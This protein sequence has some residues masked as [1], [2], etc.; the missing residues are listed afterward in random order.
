MSCGQW[1]GHVLCLK[2]QPEQCSDCVIVPVQRSKLL[3]TSLLPSPSDATP[4]IGSAQC[5]CAVCEAKYSLHPSDSSSEHSSRAVSPHVS[6]KSDKH[7]TISIPRRLVE[8]SHKSLTV[9]IPLKRLHNKQQKGSKVTISRAH[10]QCLLETENGLFKSKASVHPIIKA[11]SR[12]Y[13]GVKVLSFIRLPLYTPHQ[14][15]HLHKPVSLRSEVETTKQ[16]ELRQLKVSKPVESRQLLQSG[17]ENRSKPVESRQL[18]Q[19]REENRSE[20]VES[21]QLLQSGEENR[22]EPVESRHLYA[23]SPLLQILYDYT[24]GDVNRHAH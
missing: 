17:E 19:S 4:S 12:Q 22:S 21:R 2:G 3:P 5:K 6:T 18:L 15:L 20:P 14:L 11:L 13:P 1:M 9:S 24:I 8:M 23:N 10:F 16:V 7:L